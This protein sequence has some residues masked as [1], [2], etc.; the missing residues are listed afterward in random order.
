MKHFQRTTKRSFLLLSVI[1][2]F[3]QCKVSN[4]SPTTDI[5]IDFNSK[6]VKFDHF[7]KCTGITPAEALFNKDM[8]QNLNYMG[9]SGNNGI[10]YFRP[11]Y[12]LN[13]VCVEGIETECP[14]YNWTFLDSIT[15]LIVNNNLV[16]IFEIMGIPSSDLNK[17]R[18]AINL[19]YN[20]QVEAMD[21]YFNNFNEL[22][23][24]LAF[25]RLVR[26]VLIHLAERYGTEEVETWYYECTNEPDYPTFWPFGVQ[27]YLNYWDACVEGIKESKLNIRFGGPA[28]DKAMKD[29]GKTL[30]QHCDTG[31][32]YLTGER[33]VRIDYV[34]IHA[35]DMPNMVIARE[36][37]AL[38]Y[39][40]NN[41][42]RFS[43]LPFLN[44]EADPS[45]GWSSKFWW[46]PTSWYAG[47]I[48]EMAHK[49]LTKMIVD[50]GVNYPLLSN[51]NAFTGGWYYRSYHARFAD[52]ANSSNFSMINK[53]CYTVMSLL[54]M[55]GNE[56]INVQVPDSLNKHLGVFAT[57]NANEGIC[58]LIYNNPEIPIRIN[59]IDPIP[60]LTDSVRAIIEKQ[61]V[62]LD[63]TLN[64]LPFINPVIVEYRI[65]KDNGNPFKTW[66]EQGSPLKPDLLQ[67]N[68]M[69]AAQEPSLRV[70]PR[71][72]SLEGNTATI[73]LDLPYASVSLVVINEKPVDKP[74][75]IVNLRA[76]NYTGVNGNPEIALRWN[77]LHNNGFLSYEV[78]SAPTDG[79][80][81]KINPANLLDACFVHRINGKTDGIQYKVR[82]IDIAGNK[83]EFSETLS[84]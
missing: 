49:H 53:P 57:K 28:T 67:L 78:W 59:Y 80:F 7:W 21:T 62:S 56:Y 40:R 82:A 71:N 34:T 65:D 33:G 48:A 1:L 11:H 43:N 27:G 30:I 70:S 45:W 74:A 77:Q 58:V 18:P 54:S 2:L 9:G 61:D 32:N 12:M 76:D 4:D 50:E 60:E 79:E 36:K 63:L 75:K 72:S 24:L 37:E 83:G 84:L 23:K 29:L 47:F 69:Q 41:H 39:I 46:R 55:L 51:D 22:D 42:P 17:I 68:E 35:K 64:N 6:T 5:E 66:Q 52:E 16:P 73:N 38:D 19:H 31:I 8:Q 3:V 20:E 44:N 10:V 81:V 26:D 25:K 13:L 15:D 14:V